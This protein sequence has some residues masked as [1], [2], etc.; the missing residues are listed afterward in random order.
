MNQRHIQDDDYSFQDPTIKNLKNNKK[1]SGAKKHY[2]S[3]DHSQNNNNNNGNDDDDDD[4]D[5]IR[6]V[7][8]IGIENNN[9]VGNLEEFGLSQYEARAYLTMIGKGSLSASEIAYYSH[10][11]RTKIYLTLKKLEKKGLS[12]ISQQK[13]LICSAIN[14]TEAFEEIVIIQEKRLMNMKKV[15][16]KLQKIND[17]SNYLKGLEEKRYFILDPKSTLQKLSALIENSR[18][19]IIAILDVWGL[20]L[21]SQCKSLLI[22]AIAKGVKIK[23][24]ISNQCIDSED[25]SF[26]PNE[27]IIKVGNVFS[28]IIILD[29]GNIINIDGGNGKAALFPSIDILGFSYMKIFE[30]EWKKAIEIKNLNKTESVTQLKAV[31]LIRFI[32]DLSCFSTFQYLSSIY[33][34]ILSSLAINNR[35]NS[36][37][38]PSPSHPPSP[39]H[40]YHNYPPPSYHHGQQEKENEN[41]KEKEDYDDN[42][43]ILNNT[44]DN[45]EQIYDY[46]S[47]SNFSKNHI[48]FINSLKRYGV[49]LTDFTIEELIQM[50]DLILKMNYSGE[51]KFDRNNNTL[52]IHSKDKNKSLI[53]LTILLSLYFINLKYEI[54][55]TPK[56]SE[57]SGEI[58]ISTF[59][60]KYSKSLN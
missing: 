46:N 33:L 53:I 19:S 11:P 18:T 58:T 31:Q 23:L 52:S 56:I 7:N 10:L 59:H 40:L 13:P 3:N 16:D 15:I 20:R 6:C 34:S 57:I 14:P 51:L 30:E 9:L 29:S 49:N 35:S 21:I 5:T 38:S 4:D 27:I 12:V 24:L 25:L 47:K 42:T 22:K 55:I 32:E 54:D 36:S 37:I 48:S 2:F 17:K 8:D 43:M 44:K 50:V 41:E 1:D 60:I 39:T 45:R 26:L 28:N